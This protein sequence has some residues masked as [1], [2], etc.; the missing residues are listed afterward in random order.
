MQ[1][2]PKA[3]QHKK[4]K[5]LQL[6]FA[7][8]ASTSVAAAGTG[9]RLVPVYWRFTSSGI[10]SGVIYAGTGGSTLIMTKFGAA[11][12]GDGY[13]WDDNATSNKGLVLEMEGAVGVGQFQV[14]YVVKRMGAGSDGLGQ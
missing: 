11:A 14:W 3:F 8:A 10:G 4:L 7:T 1:L 9:L 6:D 5:L 12:A 2:V 13:Y